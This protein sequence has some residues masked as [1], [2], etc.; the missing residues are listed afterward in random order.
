[1]LEWVAAEEL[2]LF[3]PELHLELLLTL[4]LLFVLFL[5]SEL[6]LLVVMMEML[7]LLLLH[8]TA[9]AGVLLSSATFFLFSRFLLLTFLCPSPFASTTLLPI[10]SAGSPPSR[11]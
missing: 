5:V 10:G 9:A 1:M 3:V 2:E 8:C 4:L 6:L 7:F 11:I